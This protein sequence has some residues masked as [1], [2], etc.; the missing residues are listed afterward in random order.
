MQPTLF[1]IQDRSR[2]NMSR[3]ASRHDFTCAPAGSITFQ[4]I[5]NDDQISLYSLD[6]EAK[7]AVFVELAPGVDLPQVPFFHQT[8]FEQAQRL[9]TVPYDQLPELV[10]ITPTAVDQLILIHNIGRCGS[11]LLHHALNQSGALI[12]LSEPDVFGAFVAL[13]HGSPDENQHLVDLLRLCL[14][15]TF[16][17]WPQNRVVA[18]KFRGQ[19]MKIIDLMHIAF[20]QAAHL[21]LYR[22]AIDWAASI[23]RLVARDRTPLDMS[24]T[25]AIKQMQLYMGLTIDEA[26]A[27]FNPQYETVTLVEYLAIEW[28]LMLDH[29]RACHAQDM[30]MLA[31]RYE[32]LTH[33]P[34]RSLEAIFDYCGL[35]VS[36]VAGALA[37]FEQD[38][39]RGTNLARDNESSGNTEG[40]T[41]EQINQIERVLQRHPVV[42]SADT[43]LPGTLQY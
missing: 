20:P 25:A 13:R 6:D 29:Y 38:S 22:N 17:Q 1:D 30:P 15:L 12:S 31:L 3:V 34:R 23:Y 36:A 16:K 19:G 21:F 10:R 26:E 28:L 9:I 35:P 11:T 14:P 37:A 24:R 2:P 41:P 32:D 42:Q 4:Q 39:Q 33:H 8:Q 27:A 43:I 40:L 18:L 5:S 7:Q